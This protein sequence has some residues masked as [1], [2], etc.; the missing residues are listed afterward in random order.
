[1]SALSRR[2]FITRSSLTVAAA[3][4]VSALPALPMAVSDVEAEAPE[5]DSTVA[6]TDTLVAPFVA[7]VKDLQTGEMALYTGE[8][9]VLLHNPAL[10]ARLFNAAK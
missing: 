8:R 9:E 3:G 4:L 6:D 2:R 1:M 7:H 5:V 10:A